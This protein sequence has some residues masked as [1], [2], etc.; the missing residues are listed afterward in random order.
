LALLAGVGMAAGLGA[1]LCCVAHPSYLSRKHTSGRTSLN[2]LNLEA[3]SRSQRAPFLSAMHPPSGASNSPHLD[4][5]GSDSSS[6]SSPVT[7]TLFTDGVE[8]LFIP[9]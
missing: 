5:S 8:S 2:A 4:S 7:D 3:D 1:Y 6:G 9:E